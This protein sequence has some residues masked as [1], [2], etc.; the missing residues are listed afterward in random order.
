MKYRNECLIFIS[1]LIFYGMFTWSFPITDPVESNYA[2]TAKEMLLSHDFLSMRIYGEYWY[3]K[4]IFTYWMLIS[5]YKIFGINEFAA[6]F[7]MISASSL[8]VAFIYWFVWHNEKSKT[9][10]FLS[11]FILATS[12][13]FW[14]LSRIIVTDAFLFFFHNAA[15]GLFYLAWKKER[16]IYGIIAYIAL[17]LAVLTKGPIG[18]LLPMLTLLA[19]IFITKSWGMFKYL[20]VWQGIL[21]FVFV[22]M[23]WYVYMFIHHGWDFID[24]FIGLHNIARATISEHPEM[25]VFYYYLL[26]LPVALLPWTG[27]FIRTIYEIIK[28]RNLTDR[29]W[30][31]LIWL[32][33]PVAFY[34][35][36]A[37]KYLTYSFPVLF[38]AAILSAYTLNEFLKRDDKK[39]WLWVMIPML[40][41]L[42]GIGVGNAKAIKTNEEFIYFGCAIFALWGGSSILFAREQ[43]KIL[44]NI[45]VSFILGYLLLAGI[46]LPN[47]A[48][49]RTARHLAA[50]IPPNAIVENIGDY[51]TSALFYWNGEIKSVILPDEHVDTGIWSRKYLYPREKLEYFIERTKEEKEVYL[52]VHEYS[53]S[54]FS[55]M[56]VAKDYYPLVSSEK[57]TLYKKRLY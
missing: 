25:N 23:P 36:M 41:L 33:L 16:V 32:V 5:S 50:F 30:F 8:S 40:F 46:I 24:S 57:G 11:T 35:C 28:K 18:F 37:T 4:P 56:Q 52:I 31:Y 13:Q 51:Q 54:K 22:G 38:P 14:V 9:M 7:P 6:R 49:M 2:L 34:T 42:L 19:Y 47:Y 3:D 48:Q 20:Y 55:Q 45:A 26:V 12:L 43:R 17:G 15:L 39:I 21:A 10:A 29:N 27:I 53:L 1:C 44:C